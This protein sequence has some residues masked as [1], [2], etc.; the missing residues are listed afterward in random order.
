MGV[1]FLHIILGH[2]FFP[3]NFPDSL[4]WVDMPPSMIP[5]N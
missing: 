3:R 2:D 5:V 4:L 1:L